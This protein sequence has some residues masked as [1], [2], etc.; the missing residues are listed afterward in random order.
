MADKSKPNSSQRQSPVWKRLGLGSEKDYKDALKRMGYTFEERFLNDWTK[1]FGFNFDEPIW[2]QVGKES[3][4]KLKK[5]RDFLGYKTDL[6]FAV[7]M[8]HFQ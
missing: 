6:E 3:P 8:M 1:Y 5:D 4:Q 7:R 2:I